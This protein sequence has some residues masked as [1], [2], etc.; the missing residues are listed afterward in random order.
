MKKDKEMAFNDYVK[1][2]RRSWTYN[3]L[4]EK[5][6]EQFESAMQFVKN[7]LS[8]T[9]QQRAAQMNAAYHSFLMG[10]GYNGFSWR[11]N[12]EI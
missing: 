2:F 1:V 10:V 6:R 8:G 3:R 5:E 12:H 4:T 11:E 7:T 9:Y